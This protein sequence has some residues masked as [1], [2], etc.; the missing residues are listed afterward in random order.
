[1]KWLLPAAGAFTFLIA[2]DRR[3]MQERIHP[4]EGFR[5]RST[6]RQ[7]RKLSAISHQRSAFE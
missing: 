5:D 4:S 1:M 2:T 6:A 3:N 7:S